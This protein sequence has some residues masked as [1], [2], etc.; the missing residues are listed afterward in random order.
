MSKY[1]M[2]ALD[3]D[4][5]LLTE[6]KRISEENKTAIRMATDAGVTV[7]FAT[8]RGIQNVMP[9]A[10]ELQL[11]SPLVTVNGSEVWRDL[12]KLH[13]R[14]TL[15]VEL[16]RRM[17]GLGLHYGTWFWAYSVGDIFNR[18]RWLE[19]NELD[20]KQWLKFGYYT[21][22]TESLASI[23]AEIESWDL[24][25]ITNSHPLNIEM[26]PKGINKARGIRQV[27]EILGID[28]SQVITMGDSLNDAQMIQEAGL[29]IAMGNAQ[30]EV[31]RIADRV[32]VSNEEHG[33]AQIIREYILA[34]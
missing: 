11:H 8:G 2:I 30:E 29:G 9:Y 33:V 5:T 14:H 18:D 31:K 32:T 22:N 1:K 3:M 24:L 12:G 10:D 13:E 25:E 15:N 17:H 16:V 27:C 4:G 26:N 21:E 6:D 28:M 34:Y 20:E 23:R 19:D 7:I